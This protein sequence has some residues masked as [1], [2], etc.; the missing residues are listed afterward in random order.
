MK[1]KLVI[2]VIFLLVTGIGTYAIYS[3]DNVTLMLDYIPNTNYSGIYVALDKGYYNDEGMDL[4]IL[5]TS[6]VG[7]E[8]LVGE[9]AVD[10]GISYEENVLLAR[11]NNINI[12]SIYAM[13]EQNT[14]GLISKKSKNINSVSD[15]SGKNYCGWGSDV[16]EAIIKYVNPKINYT[17]SS[18]TFIQSDDKNCDLY[19]VFEGWDKIEVD[20]ENVNYDYFSFKDLGINEY[21]PVIITS[22]DKIK[23]NKE[24]VT[25]FIRA[26]IK[27]YEDVLED[28]KE[29]VKIFLKYNPEYD[30][31][32]ITSSINY[33]VNYYGNGK[34]ADNVWESLEKILRDN[35]IIKKNNEEYYTNEFVDEYYKSSK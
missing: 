24:E 19:W 13:L 12:K 14:S 30:E 35:E 15:M 26:T 8:T 32:F 28:P 5:E 22:D 17:I 16:E 23:N 10:Y 33:L 25:K 2:L 21:T 11:E 6:D 4:K 27:G 31:E 29:A 34:I 3:K 9:G 1:K 7:V 20:L 18:S